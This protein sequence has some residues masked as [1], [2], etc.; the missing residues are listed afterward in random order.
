MR[1]PQ[2]NKNIRTLKDDETRDCYLMR[3]VGS[4]Q[5][6]LEK[7]W[8]IDDFKNNEKR[9][10]NYLGL[11]GFTKWE[12]IGEFKEMPEN[13]FKEFYHRPFEDIELLMD[14]FKKYG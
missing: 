7:R 3:E 13:I 12:I 6:R 5:V 1:L 8:I 11:N 4:N 10:P 2:V 9:M 14:E